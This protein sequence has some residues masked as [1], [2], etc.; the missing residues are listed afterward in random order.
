MKKALPVI[1]IEGTEFIVD[2]LKNELREKAAPQNTVDIGQMLYVGRGYNFFYDTNIKNIAEF[3]AFLDF[4]DNKHIKDVT[5]PNLTELDPE[6]MAEKYKTALENIKGKTDFELDIIPGSLLDMRWNKKILPIVEIGGHPFYVDLEM[7][8][9]CPKDDPDSKGIDLQQIREYYNRSVQA[10]IIP[11][12]P[13]TREFQEIDHL[14]ITELPKDIIIVKFPHTQEMDRVGWN[15][16]YGFGPG[17]HINET[18]YTLHFKAVTLPW[19]KTNIPNSIKLNLQAQHQAEKN[20]L[21]S[22]ELP[23][24]PPEI[25]KGRKM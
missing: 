12:N 3:E 8:K 17:H 1:D 24:I 9:L 11:Y 18:E 2:V 16:Q 23:N 13:S 22:E 15:V 7:K 4:A 6:G 5:I 25:K 14:T 10:Y 19:E 20:K 21:T